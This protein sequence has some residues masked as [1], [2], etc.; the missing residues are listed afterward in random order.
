MLSGRP[1]HEREVKVEDGAE[2][3]HVEL[4]IDGHDRRHGFAIPPEAYGV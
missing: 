3:R 4:D 2:S 1:V